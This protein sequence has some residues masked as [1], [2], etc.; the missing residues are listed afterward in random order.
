MT[1]C[2]SPKMPVDGQMAT[3]MDSRS[4][5]IV[6]LANSISELRIFELIFLAVNSSVK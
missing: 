3:S 5:K 6:R 4:S 1:H 2:L